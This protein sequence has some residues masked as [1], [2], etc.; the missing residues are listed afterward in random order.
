MIKKK[1]KN[2][3]NEAQ[4]LPLEVKNSINRMTLEQGLN[5][6]MVMLRRKVLKINEAN[7]N[8]MKLNSISKV[9]L[10]DH[11]VGLILILIGLK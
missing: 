1:C 10:Q 2:N 8:K 5:A 9:I 6:Q 4:F 7:K 11:N 3:T